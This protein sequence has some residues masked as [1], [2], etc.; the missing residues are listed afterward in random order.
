MIRAIDFK[1]YFGDIVYLKTDKDQ[2][3]RIVTLITLTPT[4]ILYQL[5]QDSKT[6]DHYDFE[7]SITKDILLTTDN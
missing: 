5:S 4:G 1:Y 3:P 6:S 7:I 2:C